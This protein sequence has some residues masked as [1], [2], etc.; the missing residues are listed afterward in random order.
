MKRG[1]HPSPLTSTY[2]PI[3][4]P[5]TL[6]LREDLYIQRPPNGEPLPILVQLTST[7]DEQPEVGV[8]FSGG[9]E[10]PVRKGRR[11]IGDEFITP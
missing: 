10:T 8:N 5:L 2:L 7:A 6:I 4:H 11:T 3:Y 1:P 9:K